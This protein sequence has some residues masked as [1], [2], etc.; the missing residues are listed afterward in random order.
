MVNTHNSEFIIQAFNKGVSSV[1]QNFT[2]VNYFLAHLQNGIAL[3]SNI[4][5]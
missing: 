5:A 1:F 4:E 2:E 3:L